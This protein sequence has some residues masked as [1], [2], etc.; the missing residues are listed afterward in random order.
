MPSSVHNPRHPPNLHITDDGLLAFIDGDVL[1]GDLLLPAVPMPPQR[2]H[3]RRKG[4]RQLV[5]RPLGAVLLRDV[6]GLRETARHRQRQ[7]P[8]CEWLAA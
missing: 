8:W 3:L 6:L 7:L 4:P 5:E 2:L 1:D